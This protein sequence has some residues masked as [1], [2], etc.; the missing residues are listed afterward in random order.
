MKILV[1]C[2]FS[3]IVRDAFINQG[4]DAMSCDILPTET[5]G[6]HY[7]GDI[8]DILHGNWDMLIAHPPCTYLSNAGVQYMKNNP[9]REKLLIEAAEFFNK[10]LNAPIDKIAIENPIQHRFARKLIPKYNQTV[11]MNWFG[12]DACKPTCLWLKNLSV[13]GVTDFVEYESVAYPNGRKTSAWYAKNR[14]P[15]SRSKTFTGFANAMAEKWGSK[16]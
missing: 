15:K 14:D 2:E 10:L 4:H 9:T 16:F 8:L 3:G 13:L 1:G 5:P 7:Q 12:H 11:R 6:P